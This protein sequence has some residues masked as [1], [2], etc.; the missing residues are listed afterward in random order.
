L[1]A[2]ANAD[3]MAPQMAGVNAFDRSGRSILMRLTLVRGVSTST[4]S[5]AKSQLLYDAPDGGRSLTGSNEPE[6]VRSHLR[7]AQTGASL[8]DQVVHDH[9]QV[10]GVTTAAWLRPR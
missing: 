2:L 3:S 10:R 4:V 8:P 7:P 1:S 9:C 6:D 5:S